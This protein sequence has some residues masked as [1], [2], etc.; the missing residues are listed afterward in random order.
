MHVE[1][2]PS[3]SISALAKELKLKS[4][5]F[6]NQSADNYPTNPVRSG[7]IQYFDEM[8]IPKNKNIEKSVN[9][10]KIYWKQNMRDKGENT[11][12]GLIP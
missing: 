8:V 11:N 3:L 6:K 7:M 9:Q 10:R 12:R 1:C 4:P 5:M 2:P